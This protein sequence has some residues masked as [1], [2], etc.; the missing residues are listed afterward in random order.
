MMY[1][2]H[3]LNKHLHMSML[4]S[5]SY[6]PALFEITKVLNI[7]F[8]RPRKTNYPYKINKAETSNRSRRATDRTAA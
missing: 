1:V 3:C 7:F 4:F 2:R 6:S 8:L 5:E